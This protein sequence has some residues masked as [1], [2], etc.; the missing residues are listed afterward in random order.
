[1][2]REHIAEHKTDVEEINN[3]LESIRSENHEFRDIVVGAKFLAT[4]GKALLIMGGLVGMAWAAF[5]ALK[6]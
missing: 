5:L 2:L 6:K 3:K 4:T 1:M